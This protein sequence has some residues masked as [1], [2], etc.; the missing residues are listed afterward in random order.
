ME[1]PRCHTALPDYAAFCPRC[2]GRLDGAT[3][4]CDYR[5][6]A[7]IS[8]RHL[9]LDA[10]VAKQVQR[11]IETFR[12]PRGAAG[13][14]FPDW[15][16]SGKG[17]GNCF[18]DQDE[19]AATHSL[20]ESIRQALV[21]S[22]SLIVVCSPQTKE[23]PWVRQEIEMFAQ[24]H[25]RER[26]VCVLASGSSEESI[27]PLLRTRLLPDT[28]GVMRE[29]PAQPLAADLR[30]PSKSQRKLELLRTIAA[31][32]GCN[33]DD[34]RQRQR[35]RKRRCI[36]V[37]VAT[38]LALAALIGGLIYSTASST[39]D[40]LIAESK[41]LALASKEQFAHG[42]RIAAIETALA[43]LPASESDRSRPLVPEA[44]E[45]LEDALLVYEDTTSRFRPFFTLDCPNPIVSFVAD[46]EARWIAA[47][48]E[49]GI[50]HGYSGTNGNERYA[51]DLRELTSES[52]NIVIEEWSLTAS[53]NGTLIVSNSIGLGNL[54]AFDGQTGEPLW[55]HENI[56][57]SAIC[58][59]KDGNRL[60]VFG[61][62]S[63][64]TVEFAIL[65]TNSGEAL[66]F[67]EADELDFGDQPVPH[68]LPSCLSLENRIAAV[69]SGAT[70]LCFD[71]EDGSSTVV[72]FD[73]A[74]P[75]APM[76]VASL[77]AAPKMLLAAVYDTRTDFHGEDVPCGFVAS[78]PFDG[79]E[80]PTWEVEG[81]YDYTISGPGADAVA[82]NGTPR[83]QCLLGGNELSAV[84]TAGQTLSVRSCANGDELL[85]EDFQG[86]VLCVRSLYYG[87][88]E[89]EAADIF[90]LVTS[91]GT[92]DVQ[93]LHMPENAYFDDFRCVLPHIL[94]QAEV[95]TLADDAT[96][97]VA[98]ASDLPTRILVYGCRTADYAS[99]GSLSLDQLIGIA[100]WLLEAE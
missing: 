22:R 30:S 81:T 84:C 6:A 87:D 8:Y 29:M 58:A 28:A 80:N 49:K 20:P 4:C 75:S 32:T 50:V 95:L 31:V 38:T 9:P 36:A 54:A 23:S 21:Q 67:A 71:P 78:A 72:Q 77:M 100:H 2:G 47:L 76:A 11:A 5:Y 85:R 99:P 26:I 34:L 73:E 69:Y 16:K 24:L 27:P 90:F 48:D 33:F 13:A 41:N 25:G 15:P 61:L 83:I 92:I 86:S 3:E 82:C 1:C 62:T 74:G 52:D 45:A 66:A 40:A 70:A 91:D 60:A 46:E 19:L 12:M 96:V 55:E 18:R 64:R 65:D 43:A 10:Q 35:T 42:D 39:R 56:R 68:L 57:I 51:I 94:D 88:V 17:L 44:K 37:A 59:S 79:E 98:H 93:A 63:K 7:F 97:V 89:D 14:A 53:P